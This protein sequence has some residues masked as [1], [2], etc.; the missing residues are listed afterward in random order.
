MSKASQDRCDA[1]DDVIPIA[2]QFQVSKADWIAW[3][4]SVQPKVD[5][6]DVISVDGEQLRAQQESIKV[7]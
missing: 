5:E 6:L 4:Q 3:L 1:L 7:W 2:S